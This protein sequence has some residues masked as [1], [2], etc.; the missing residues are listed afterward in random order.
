MNIIDLLDDENE[1]EREE[2]VME[3]H[4]SRVAYIVVGLKSISSSFPTTSSEPVATI[5]T[6]SK[7]LEVLR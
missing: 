5:K 7:E 4:E 2:A 1:I 6:E 3:E